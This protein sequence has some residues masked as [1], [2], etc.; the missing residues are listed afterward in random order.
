MINL[1]ILSA[2]KS[3][4]VHSRLNLNPEI[5]ARKTMLNQARQSCFDALWVA[6]A[7]GIFF[8][9]SCSGPFFKEIVLSKNFQL[10]HI[11]GYITVLPILLLGV[12]L[13]LGARIK[14]LAAAQ[15]AL[16][17]ANQEL[18]EALGNRHTLEGILP[19]CSFCKN[20]RD[21]KGTWHQVERYIQEHSNAACSHS[22]CP[23]C[24]AEHYPAYF[25]ESLCRHRPEAP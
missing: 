7:I 22:I 6:M 3:F 10:Y 21:E 4:K 8:I 16:I 14:K 13:H 11:G 1:L 24:M 19:I 2:I 5:S 12:I 15:D 18:T 23:T 17:Q 25:A 9:A 20:I